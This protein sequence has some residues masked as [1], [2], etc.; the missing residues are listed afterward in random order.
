MPKDNN[1]QSS[2]TN[3][4]TVVPTTTTDDMPP[5]VMEDTAPP[6]LTNSDHSTN[7]S[8]GSAAPSNDVV[9]PSVVIGT[10]PKKKFAGGRVIATI[11]GL[12][13]LVGGIGAGIVLVNQNQNIAEKAAIIECFPAGTKITTVDGVKNIEEFGVGDK[14]LSEN[15]NGSKEISSTQK[16]W[17][18]WSFNMCSVDFESGE[19]LKLTNPHPLYTKEGWKAINVKSALE[20]NPELKITEL[21][22]SDSVKKQNG[23]WDKI[24]SISCEY[25]LFRVYNLAVDNNNNYYAEGF[26][27]HNK[28]G[29]AG[30]IV[31]VGETVIYDEVQDEIIDEENPDYDPNFSGYSPNCVPNCDGQD[32]G[33]DGCGGS[34]GSCSGGTICGGGGP[35]KCGVASGGCNLTQA[36]L[37]DC[38]PITPE[39]RGCLD[40]GCDTATTGNICHCQGGVSCDYGVCVPQSNFVT[41]CTGDGRVPSHNPDEEG[42]WT[43]CAAGYVAGPGLDGCVPATGSGGGGGGTPPEGTP[44]TTSITAQCQNVKAYSSNWTLLTNAQLSQL[45]AGSSVNFCV[46][47]TS[48][49]GSAFDKAQFTISSPGD[50]DI[51]TTI[52]T[53]VRPSSTDYCENYII[54]AGATTFN[55]TAQIHHPTLGWK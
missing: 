26:L 10:T 46:A 39:G 49:N 28:T 19:K 1:N 3:T 30:V 12:F 48:S 5:V 24:T 20:H 54:P 44:P 22:E 16:L 52:T 40:N 6:M 2:I 23:T 47:G 51:V 7:T 8:T 32:C 36:L 50:E 11:L 13:L 29:G 21:T 53:S 35:G 17:K 18:L 41:A 55:V 31:P 45:K 4:Q 42:A 33:S 27:A 43:C 25:G 34:C 38:N 14:V 9:M 15:E 37:G